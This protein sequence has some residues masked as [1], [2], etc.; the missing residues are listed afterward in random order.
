[1]RFWVMKS[2]PDVFSIDDLKR[3]KK[4]GWDCVRNYQARN[5][6]RDDMQVGDLVLYYHSNAEPSGVAGVAKVVPTRRSSTARA[7]TTT[8]PARRTRRR[9]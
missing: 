6:M 1:M 2:E 8:R 9:G 7:S 4:T 5:S 3:E